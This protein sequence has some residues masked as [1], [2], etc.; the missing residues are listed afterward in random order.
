M[1]SQ[2]ETKKIFFSSEVAGA[3]P[4]P[5]VPGPALFYVQKRLPQQGRAV[6][7]EHVSSCDHPLHNLTA[8]LK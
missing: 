1:T 5:S 7:D 3:D 2:G 8:G 4:T 6:G